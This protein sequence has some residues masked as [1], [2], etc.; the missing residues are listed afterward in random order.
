MVP[1]TMIPTSHAILRSPVKGLTHNYHNHVWSTASVMIQKLPQDRV[2]G[3]E[4]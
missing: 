1:D 3:S 4:K 2:G